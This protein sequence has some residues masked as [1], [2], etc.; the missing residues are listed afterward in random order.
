MCRFSRGINPWAKQRW[1]GHRVI[2]TNERT[3]A[4]RPTGLPNER[5]NVAQPHNERFYKMVGRDFGWEKQL[6]DAIM[7]VM[8]KTQADQLRQQ[9]Q[10][11]G[12]VA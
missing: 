9:Q 8:Q 10:Y 1:N 4:T 11:A 6:D 5:T 2:S 12:G 3:D 7:T